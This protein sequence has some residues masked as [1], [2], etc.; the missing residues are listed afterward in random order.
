MQ[1][2]TEPWTVV[3]RA[4]IIMLWVDGLE[5]AGRRA[6]VAVGGVAVVALLA[7]VERAV[8]AGR[9]RGFGLAAVDEARALVVG[10]A[11]ALAIADLVVVLLGLLGLLGL[12]RVQLH[13]HRGLLLG[14]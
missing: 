2:R 7:G 5:A 14:D 13:E 3:S 11:W 12:G 10:L 9:D 1:T 6:A 8:T 4:R